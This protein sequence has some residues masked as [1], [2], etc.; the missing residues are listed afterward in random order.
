VVLVL[1]YGV[2]V[3]R[4]IAPRGLSYRLFAWRILVLSNSLAGCLPIVDPPAVCLKDVSHIAAHNCFNGSR[5]HVD[6]VSGDDGILTIF[7][8]AHVARQSM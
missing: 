3:N 5:Q 1:S 8:G 7:G 4:V 2:F 6:H